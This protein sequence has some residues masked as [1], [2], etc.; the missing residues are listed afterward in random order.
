LHFRSYKTLVV[1]VSISLTFL[2]TTLLSHQI[3]SEK[4]ELIFYEIRNKLAIDHIIGH[5]AHLYV[6]NYEDEEIELLSFQ[7]DP[8]RIQSHLDPIE[9]SISKLDLNELK[10]IYAIKF[11]QVA[12]KKIILFDS[13]TFH[14]DFTKKI[15]SDY[16]VINNGA[17]KSLKWLCK[18][19][20][21]N[22]L[23]LTNANSR[24][25]TKKMKMEASALGIDLHSLKM[26]GALKVSLVEDIKKERTIMPALFTTN[27]D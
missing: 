24:Y 18:H 21:F 12:S 19:F 4:Q 14:L 16:I 22:K 6:D 3:Q 17:V 8:Y 15:S 7:I 1:S 11:C 9:N 25:Y 27:P 10:N 26:D 23:I 5:K 20:D 13:T 2:S